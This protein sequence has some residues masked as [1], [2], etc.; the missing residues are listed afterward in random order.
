MRPLQEDFCI[1]P[2]HW[3]LSKEKGTGSQIKLACPN[4]PVSLSSPSPSFWFLM[5]PCVHSA[6]AQVN[7]EASDKVLEVEQKY[8]EI[9]RPV[10]NRR[11]DIIGGISDFWLTAVS[12]AAALT[13]PSPVVPDPVIGFPELLCVKFQVS[14][15][16]ADRV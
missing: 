11:N 1:P 6:H 13:T 16:C 4:V 5:G 10:Y 2:E 8:N 7:E 12:G 15:C 9:R 3:D 14:N